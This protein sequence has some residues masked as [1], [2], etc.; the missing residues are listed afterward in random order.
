MWVLVDH[1]HNHNSEPL[2]RRARRIA[3]CCNRAK[4][5]VRASIVW[6]RLPEILWYDYVLKAKGCQICVCVCV[7]VCVFINH[8]QLE[9]ITVIAHC[10]YRGLKG[11]GPKRCSVLTSVLPVD[12]PVATSKGS[13]SHNCNAAILKNMFTTLLMFTSLTISGCF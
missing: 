11:E 5:P 8:N 13:D 9:D 6:Q 1:N 4:W 2:R 7:C 3:L 10:N 12:S